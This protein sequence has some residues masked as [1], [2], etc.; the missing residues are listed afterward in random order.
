LQIGFLIGE[1]KMQPIP[2]AKEGHNSDTWTKW[3]SEHGE[4]DTAALLDAE[5]DPGKEKS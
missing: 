5:Q 1:A 2:P 3:V 4:S